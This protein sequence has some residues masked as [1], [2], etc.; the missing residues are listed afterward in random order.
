MRYKK[1]SP[2]N[3]HGHQDTEKKNEGVVEPEPIHCPVFVS[4][5]KHA[6]HDTDTKNKKECHGNVSDI[7]NRKN[8]RKEMYGTEDGK[9]TEQNGEVV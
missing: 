8:K 4:A 9:C 3:E 2:I 1:Q 6:H 7:C 5:D